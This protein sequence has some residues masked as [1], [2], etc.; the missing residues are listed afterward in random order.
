MTK[1]KKT[2]ERCRFWVYSHARDQDGVR[3][4]ACRCRG[5]AIV[6]NERESV[7]PIMRTTEWC[8]DWDWNCNKKAEADLK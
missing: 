3:L 7:F 4:G 2:C 1:G 8:G 5:P 6:D